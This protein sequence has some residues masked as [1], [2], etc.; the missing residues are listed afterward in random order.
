[1]A[2]EIKTGDGGKIKQAVIIEDGNMHKAGGVHDMITADG[3]EQI[4]FG[5][6]FGEIKIDT[7]GIKGKERAAGAGRSG[8]AVDINGIVGRDGRVAGVELQVT[9]GEGGGHKAKQKSQG[10]RKNAFHGKASLFFITVHEGTEIS[11]GGRIAE[12]S[13]PLVFEKV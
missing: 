7:E 10:K 2:C 6:G 5:F 3:G 8:G 12:R 13:I 11:Q 4:R 1:M 9:F